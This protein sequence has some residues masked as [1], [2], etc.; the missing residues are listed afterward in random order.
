MLRMLEVRDLR[1]SYGATVALAGVS[2]K[3]ATGEMFGLL[4]P[5]GAGKTTLMSIVSGLLEPSAGHVFLADK[6]FHRSDREM[7]RLIGIVP[8]ELAI[9]N[10]LSARENLRFFG[11]LY[12]IDSRT[13][14]QR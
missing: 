12:G 3:V 5:N 14:E 8:Q 7:R 4:G 9:Y 1:R 6:E 10:E 11:Q 2:C 13:L